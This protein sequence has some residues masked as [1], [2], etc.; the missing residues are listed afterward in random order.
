[1][2]PLNAVDGEFGILAVLIGRVFKESEMLQV[3]DGVMN[4][5]GEIRIIGRSSE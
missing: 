2:I 5:Q 1:M 4:I 3:D